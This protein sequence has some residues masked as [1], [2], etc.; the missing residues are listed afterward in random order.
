MMKTRKKVTRKAQK[1]HQKTHILKCKECGTP[2]KC[3]FSAV[4]VECSTCVSKK[5]FITVKKTKKTNTKLVK[6]RKK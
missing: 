2:V 5:G 6:K 4:V 1:L 3:D